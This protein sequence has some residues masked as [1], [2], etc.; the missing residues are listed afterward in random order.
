M[1]LGAAVV[2]LD[3]DEIVQTKNIRQIGNLTFYKRGAKW[4][5]AEVAKQDLAKLETNSGTIMAH[6]YIDA[7]GDD[8]VY[9]VHFDSNGTLLVTGFSL[10]R[11][12]QL[13]LQVFDEQGTLLAKLD[14]EDL[15]LDSLAIDVAAGTYFIEVGDVGDNHDGEYLLAVDHIYAAV[16]DPVYDS[17]SMWARLPSPFPPD[18]VGICVIGVPSPCNPPELWGPF[19]WQLY[20]Q[21]LAA[22]SEDVDDDL[23]TIVILN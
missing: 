7:P 15:W 23:I 8:D 18:A 10:G 6:S 16:D 19:S 3:N 2:D 5:S 13:D 14:P 4:V 1:I 21:L 17:S 11:D 22:W 12:L 20:Y 9:Q